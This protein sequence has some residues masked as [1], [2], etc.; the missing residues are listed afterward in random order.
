MKTIFQLCTDLEMVWDDE[1]DT[2]PLR[3]NWAGGDTIA[4][5]Q[6]EAELIVE[7]LTEMLQEQQHEA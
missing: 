2:L 6:R 1:S 4:T 3:F 5:S 7:H